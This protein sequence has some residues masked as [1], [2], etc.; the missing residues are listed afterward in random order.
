MPKT[1]PVVAPT[2][3]EFEAAR[4]IVSQVAIVT[5]VLHSNYLTD[6]T[7][8]EVYLKAENLQ[9]TGAYKI[10]GAYN[11]MTKLTADE[12]K[13]GV[14]AASAGNHAQ[15]V[16]LAAKKL[17]IKATIFMPIGAS[18]PKLQATENYGAEVVLTGAVFN[19]TLKAA[20]EYAAKQGAIFIPPYDHIDVVMGQGTVGLE[21]MEQVPDVENI[22][23]AIGGGGLAAGLAVA[24]KLT[25]AESG[26][27]IKV[28]GVQS[29]HAAPYVPSLKSGELT[30]ITISRTIADGIA[31]GKPGRIPFELIKQHVDKVV[32]VS[33]DEIAKAIVVLMERSKQ[34]VEPAGAVA[35]AALMSGAFKP[36]GKTVA[37]L[38]GGNIDPLLMQKV[39]GHGLAASERYTTISVM[40]PDRPGQLV[41]TAEA[42]AAAHGNVVEVLHTRHGKGLE[43]SEVEL[44]MSV[45][46]TGH[47]HRQRVLKALQAAGLKAR[48]EAD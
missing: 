34:V 31:V 47:E 37:V 1:S 32:T 8:Q 13:L 26:R 11:R 43:I 44:R 29:E 6:L 28:I 15:G 7:G 27:K 14:V 20:Q 40:L 16:A 4:E 25:A 24:A 10:R 23:V 3:D 33:D 46:T 22:V 42:I 21:I 2:L 19:E 5:P 18:L 35:V 48:I 38:S 45:E 17:G 41:K 36:K 39:I 9:R 30:E 12:R